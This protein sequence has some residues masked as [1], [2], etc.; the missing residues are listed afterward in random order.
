MKRWRLGGWGQDKYKHLLGGVGISICVTLLLE[1]IGVPFSREIGFLSALTIGL[2]KEVVYD[3]LLGRGTPE[4][5]D[6][7][8]TGAGGGL[9]FLLM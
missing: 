4:V 6:A 2:L 5:F 8:A 3:W 9:I 1:T 7:V